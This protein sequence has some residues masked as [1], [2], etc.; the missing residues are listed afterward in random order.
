[1]SSAGSHEHHLLHAA[2]ASSPSEFTA[3]WRT[4]TGERGEAGGLTSLEHRIL[5]FV[6][7]RLRSEGLEHELTP[8]LREAYRVVWARNH[9][10]MKQAADIQELLASNGIPSTLFKGASLLLGPYHGI[11]ARRTSDIDLL[12]KRSDLHKASRLLRT[13]RPVRVHAGHAICFQGPGLV[14]VD[15]HCV[16]SRLSLI[17]GAN[18]ELGYQQVSRA[19]DASV[20]VCHDDRRFRI[21]N[22]TDLV[23]LHLVNV[24]A[25]GVRCRISD[26]VWLLDLKAAFR[27]AEPDVA[28]LIAAIRESRCSGLFQ[29]YFREFATMLP[30]EANDFSRAVLA[31]DL[32][33]DEARVAS[34]LGSLEVDA[35]AA[36]P[37]TN[38]RNQWFALRGFSPE[39]APIGVRTRYVLFAA[40]YILRTALM[41]PLP[42]ST[43]IKPPTHYF[44]RTFE[45]FLT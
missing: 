2:L 38:V 14:D 42:H 40:L 36:S 27:W 44:R 18:R 7:R 35:M 34:A 30:E 31:L 45:A 21:P 15:L 37:S 1:M 5:P 23:F 20:E 8:R 11:G 25:H 10:L 33:E 16:P 13:E 43:P 4:W 41:N 6:R 3:H 29:H 22:A 12:V 17:D 26:A 9:V 28:R 24:F 32:S 19:I 39:A